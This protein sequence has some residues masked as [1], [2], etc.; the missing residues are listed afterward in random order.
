MY[1]PP[2]LTRSS[3]TIERPAVFFRPMIAFLPFGKIRSRRHGVN[4]RLAQSSQISFRRRTS[5]YSVKLEQWNQKPWKRRWPSSSQ[6][7]NTRP[8]PGSNVNLLCPGMQNESA[9]PC[10]SIW[11]RIDITSTSRNIN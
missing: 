2:G 5:K 11:P 8:T 6:D 9:K 10:V 1:N 3:R 7:M 4:R